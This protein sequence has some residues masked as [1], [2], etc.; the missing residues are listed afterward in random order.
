MLQG[1]PVLALLA[2]SLVAFAQPAFG[3][4]H[5]YVH[6][7]KKQPIA[8]AW[9]EIRRVERAAVAVSDFS[10]PPAQSL[11]SQADGSWSLS[12]L[13]EGTWLLTVVACSSPRTDEE[14]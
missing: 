5:G 8:G 12:D 6:D 7:A 4:I 11:R 1:R 9:L 13:G 2:A 3:G 10:G 14:L